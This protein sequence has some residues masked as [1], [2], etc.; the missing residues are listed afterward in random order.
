MYLSFPHFATQHLDSAEDF[1]VLSIPAL[2]YV[3]MANEMARR[4]LTN[5]LGAVLTSFQKK[6]MPVCIVGLLS[7][8]CHC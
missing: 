4:G 8:L 1:I 6:M 5:V 3:F 7:K 2:I